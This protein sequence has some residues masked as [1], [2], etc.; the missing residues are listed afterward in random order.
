[1][2]NIILNLKNFQNIVVIGP[3]RSGTRIASKILACELLYEWYEEEQFYI[4]DYDSFS[5]ILN[6]PIRKV[7][8][9]PALTH[10]VRDF[11]EDTMVIMMMRN[12]SDIIKSQKR[13]NWKYEKEELSKYPAE[14]TAAAEAKYRFWY[15]VKTYIK[16][17][18]E[19]YYH[20][21]EEHSMF[22]KDRQR[23]EYNQTEG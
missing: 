23:F 19:L 16:N 4:E 8:Q 20:Q 1:M 13:I 21:L 18:C 7:I 6:V 3:Q 10:R 22:I 2:L 5:R 12:I 14:E 17:H 9:A 15:D 11:P